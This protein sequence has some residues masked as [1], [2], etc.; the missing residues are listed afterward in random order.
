MRVGRTIVVAASFLAISHSFAAEVDLRKCP[1]DTVVFVD[2]WA[3]GTF[4]VSRV[5]TD[6]EYVCEDGATP[7]SDLC[8]GPVG[9]L[10]LEGVLGGDVEGAGES[11]YAMY[12]VVLGAPCCDWNITIPAETVF[13]PNLKW[14]APEEVP[15]LGE[16]AFLSIDSEYGED[17]GNPFMAAA[18]TLRE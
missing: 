7:P 8:R 10:V 4:T 17:F 1:L 5:G 6:R 2:P 3:G 14:L 11:R 15:L 9:D 12:T 18:C 16:Q 13:S